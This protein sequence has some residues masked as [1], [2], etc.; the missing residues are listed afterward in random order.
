MVDFISRFKIAIMARVKLNHLKLYEL[1]GKTGT[2]PCDLAESFNMSRQLV[3]YI[4][5]HGSCKYAT[6]LAKF[7]DCK[8]DELLI[9]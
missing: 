7:F 5:H 8:E 4:L 1:M 9:R 2:R 6:R 3:H